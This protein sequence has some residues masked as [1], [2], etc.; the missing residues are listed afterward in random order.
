MRRCLGC[1]AAFVS[2]ADA[3]RLL[4]DAG[5]SSVGAG[6]GRGL[7]RG[8]CLALADLAEHTDAAF[9]PAVGTGFGSV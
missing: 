7:P 5:A 3:A 6:A 1:H 9:G 4:A 8:L 2:L